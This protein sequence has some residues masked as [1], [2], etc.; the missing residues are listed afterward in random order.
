MPNLSTRNQGILCG[1]LVLMIV[2]TRGHHFASLNNLPGATWAAFFV[3]GIY[4]GSAWVF[5][6]L[7]ALCALLDYLAITYGGV[8]SF[9]V[10]LAYVLLLPAYAALWFAGR[11]YR[12]HHRFSA[13]SLLALAGAMVLGAMVAEICSSGGFYYFSGRFADTNLTEF[14]ERFFR[15]FP[16]YLQGLAFYVGLAALVHTL[17]VL[18]KGLS[19]SSDTRRV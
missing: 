16:S 6:G 8:S 12:S 11:W 4:L 17:I 13:E 19:G 10:S 7:L 15:Y 3:A 9:C 5:A 14:A 1:V 2:L 18:S